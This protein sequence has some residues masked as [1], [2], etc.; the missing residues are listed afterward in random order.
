MSKSWLPSLKKSLF[1]G[2]ILLSGGIVDSLSTPARAS[3]NTE[4][5]AQQIAKL[6]A[7]QRE[8]QRALAS[9][10]RQMV[11]QKVRRGRR[12]YSREVQP[13]FAG[14]ATQTVIGQGNSAL[15]ARVAPNEVGAYPPYSPGAQETSALT[16]KGLITLGPGFFG[17]P[18]VETVTAQR[19][20]DLT[21]RVAPNEVGIH[22]RQTAGNQVVSAL[23]NKG[24]INIGPVT[25]SLGGFVNVTMAERNRHLASDTFTDFNVMPFPNQPG[26]YTD[27]F[28]ATARYSRI[29]ML[30]RGNLNKHSIVSGYF[31]FGWGAAANTTNYYKSNSFTMRMRQIY[32]AYDNNKYGWHVLVGQ[33]WTMFTPNRIGI[34]ARQ[35]S[36][37]ITIDWALTAGTIWARQPQI[38]VVKDMFHHRLWAG[39]SLENAA[40]IYGI[41]CAGGAAECGPA[42]TGAGTVTLPNGYQVTYGHV[43]QGLTNNSRLYPNEISP[44]IIGKLAWD[45]AWGHYEVE[46]MLTF[47]HDRVMTSPGHGHNNTAVAGGGGAS[48]IL[49]LS[50]HK[51]E[52]HLGGVVGKGIGRYGGAFLPGVTVNELG[53]PIPLFSAIA[54]TGIVGHPTKNIDVYGYF[55]MQ[56]SGR[57]AWGNGQVYGGYGSPYL[58]NAGCSY[59][60]GTC[61][62]MTHR[63]IEGTIGAWW[64]FFKG[65]FG[66]VES[67]VQLIY[68]QRKLWSTYDEPKGAKT[69]LST[70]MLSF[71]YLPFQG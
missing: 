68:A 18:D 59:E 40:N 39:I 69:D 2:T 66:T 13:S 61:Q 29:S 41:Q 47:P 55:G 35:E 44:D 50:P 33:A 52:M 58:V 70:L 45:P 43:G 17:T 31:E 60:G 71:R 11:T 36:L 8:L 9:V 30:V 1:A 38:R 67:G 57:S 64:R 28:S 25:M 53:Q 20:R 6:Q 62:G 16:N 63:I 48:M 65:R 23:G 22:P 32:L 3:S 42:Y 46:G 26:Y 21:V 34:V 37:P 24:I 19:D 51:M 4:T 49:P 7:E 56:E 12:G 5:L 27:N 15:T 54:S 10:Q 14:P